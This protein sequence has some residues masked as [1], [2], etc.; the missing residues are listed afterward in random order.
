M[1]KVL[2]VV[3]GLVVMSPQAFA[4]KTI[5]F[6]VAAETEEPTEGKTFYIAKPKEDYLGSK[7]EAII[8]QRAMTQ[9]GMKSASSSTADYR[10]EYSFELQK[11]ITGDFTIGTLIPYVHRMYV[12]AFRKDK[13]IWQLTA[14]GPFDQKNRRQL[15]AALAFAGIG[16]YGKNS[17]GDLAMNIDVHADEVNALD[18]EFKKN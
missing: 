14:A 7:R 13:A 4:D 18:P 9:Q 15:I 3:V 2:M 6:K 12:K 17:K 1:F 5:T 8:I 11:P 10:I 16:F